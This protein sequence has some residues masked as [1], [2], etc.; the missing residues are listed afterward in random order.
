MDPYGPIAALYDL[1]HDP[2]TDDVELFRNLVV[3]GPVLEIGAG[4][5]RITAALAD[6]GHEVWAVEPSAPML[7]RAADRLK[8]RADV[9]LVPRGVLELAEEDLPSSFRVAI[10]SLNMLW[11]LQS[12]AEQQ[13]ALLAVHRRLVPMGLLVVDSTNPLSMLDRGA[14][15]ELRERFSGELQD[16]EI[17]C[18]S[19]AWDD[20]AEQT[21]AVRLTYDVTDGQG[22][23]ERTASTLNLRYIYRF[24][25]ELLLEGCGF[26]QEQLYGS[27]DLEPYSVESPNLISVSRAQ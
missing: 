13:A 9:H 14:R 6:D 12:T 19:S 10:L 27:Y 11:H 24:E 8:G 5:G 4:T 16:R 15:G 2:I 3:A 25:L 22:A 7:R 23:I 20:P 1:E 21:L 17:T 18:V 26:I